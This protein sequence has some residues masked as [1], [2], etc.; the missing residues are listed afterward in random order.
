MSP[1]SQRILGTKKTTMFQKTNVS[2]KDV[3]I[4]R[5]NNS[6]EDIVGKVEI[7]KKFSPK[8]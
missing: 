2:G 3:T 8:K 7:G 6:S 1:P 4:S 5:K